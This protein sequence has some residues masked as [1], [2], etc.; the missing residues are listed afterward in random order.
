MQ[1]KKIKLIVLN[2]LNLFCHFPKG[3]GRHKKQFKGE[4]EQKDSSNASEENSEQNKDDLLQEE[5]EQNNSSTGMEENSEQKKGTH[6]SYTYMYQH[7]I[8]GHQF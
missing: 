5:E 7:R 2:I 4:E 3:D 6:E 1:T 8:S